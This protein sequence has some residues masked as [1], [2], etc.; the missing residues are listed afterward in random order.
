MFL[1]SDSKSAWQVLQRKDW[2]NLLTL[3]LLEYHHFYWIPG[4]DGINVH[5]LA[6]RASKDDLNLDTSSVPVPLHKPKGHT[7]ILPRFKQRSLGWDSIT[8]FTIYQLTL[9]TY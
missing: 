2:A 3:I 4:Y 8:N 7:Y 9:T 1:F 6:D 5:D